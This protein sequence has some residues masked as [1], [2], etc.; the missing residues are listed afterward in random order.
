MKEYNYIIYALKVIGEENIRYIGYTKRGLNKRL[1]A[2]LSQ[3]KVRDTHKDRWIKKNDFNIEI[4]L[5]E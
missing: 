3:A 2:H 4:T 5:I 1:I